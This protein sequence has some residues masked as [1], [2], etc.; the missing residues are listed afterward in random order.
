ML[1]SKIL[2]NSKITDIA[3]YITEKLLQISKHE[4]D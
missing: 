3:D 2:E 1:V 4:R